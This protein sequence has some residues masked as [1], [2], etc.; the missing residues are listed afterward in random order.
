MTMDIKKPNDMFVAVLQK[1]EL[2]VFDLGKSEIV[3]DNTQLLSADDY[4]ALPKVQEMF[5]SESGNFDENAFNLAYSKA[6]NLY[7]ELSLDSALADALEYDPMDFT[8]PMDNKSID[9]R[10][11]IN[12]DYNPFK[13]KYSQT[14]VNSID[15]SD[16]SLRELAQ[17]SKIFDVKTQTWLD[18]SANDFGL[19]GSLF[20]D[21][22]VY[23]QWDS[24][25]QSFDPAVGKVVSHKKGDWKIDNNGNLYIETLGGRE[26]YGKQVVNPLDLLTKEGTSINKIDFF[27]SDGKDKSIF[28]TTMKLASEIAPY[29]IPG[30]NIYYGGVKMAIGL[31][32]ILP[33]FYK[34]AE[35]IL[36]G[37][38]TTGI[39]TDMW[40]GMNS[41]EGFMSKYSTKSMSDES[42]GSMWN[43]EQLGSLVTDVFSQIYEQRAAA[44]LSKLFYK[45]NETEH[46]NRLKGITDEVLENAVYAGKI[47]SKQEA[48]DIATRAFQK[49]Y[50]NSASA[51]KRSALAKNLSL[52]YMALSQSASV[53]EE[54]LAAGYDR[55][56][57][58][59]TALIAATGQYA[60]M[61]NNRMGDWFLDKTTGY[62]EN[63]S[64]AVIKKLAKN[65]L[66]DSKESF[67]AFDIDKQVGKAKLAGV[68]KNFKTKLNDTLVDPVLESEF[69]E[70]IV[71]RSVIEGIEEVTEQAAIDAA[72]GIADVMSSLGFTAKKGSFGGFNNV[73]SERGL[74][75]YL[76]NLIGGMLG[77]PMFE[78]ERSIISPALLGK[79]P[80]F[81]T[82]ADIYNIVSTGRTQEL[83]KEI[84]NKKSRFGNTKL[85]PVLSKISDTESVYLPTEALSQADMI[86]NN[87]IEYVKHVDKLINSESLGNSDEDLIKK[88]IIDQI[89]IKDITKSGVDKF[90][91]SDAKEIGLEIIELRDQIASLK[92]EESSTQ[93]SELNSKLTL[94]RQQYTDLLTSKKS[95]YYHGLSLFVLNP[96]L[97]NAFINMTVDSFVKEKY[98]K[99]YYELSEVEQKGYKAEF[100]KLKDLSEGDFKSKMKLMYDA[101]LEI[102]KSFSKSLK[103]YDKDGYASIKSGF[104]NILHNIGDSSEGKINY[105]DALKRLNEVNY[106][107]VKN[108]F[109]KHS[110][111]TDTNVSVGKFL[112]DNGYILEG[113]DPEKRAKLAN[114]YQEK[115]LKYIGFE[116]PID[117]DIQTVLNQKEQLN[118]VIKKVKSQVPNYEELTIEEYLPLIFG[119]SVDL[120][121]ETIQL[122]LTTEE[123]AILQNDVKPQIDI[124]NYDVLLEQIVNKVG[125]SGEIT[126]EDLNAAGL[127]E[128]NT[129]NLEVDYN[130]N[131][132]ALKNALNASRANYESIAYKKVGNKYDEE[133]DNL[134][135]EWDSQ[136]NVWSDLS[137][138]NKEGIINYL[139]N[140]GLP[141]SG[142]NTE[143]LQTILNQ[144]NAEFAKQIDAEIIKVSSLEDSEEKDLQLAQYE[145]MKTNLKNFKV[146]QTSNLE[147]SARRALLISYGEELM[148]QS[149]AF[150]EEHI[151]ELKKESKFIDDFLQDNWQAEQEKPEEYEK[152]EKQYNQ[153]QTILKYAESN[154]KINE[155]FKKLK[156]FEIEIFGWAGPISFFDILQ[157]NIDFFGTKVEVKSDFVRSDVQ[158]EQIKKARYIINAVKSVT[159]AMS[160]TKWGVD[161]LYG[162]NVMLNK[163]LEKEGLA[164]AYEL[165]DSQATSTIF[166][167][168]NLIESKLIY[169]EDLAKHNAISIIDNDNRIK[170]AFITQVTKQYLNK[171]FETSLINLKI[172]GKSLFSADDLLKINDISDP[173][174]KLIT[175][176]DIFYT[177]FHEINLSLEEKLS[178]LFEKFIDKNNPS[179]SIEDLKTSKDSV[180]TSDFAGFE[181]LDWYN[182]LH[183][184]ISINSKKFYSEYKNNIEK[185]LS[186]Q[187]DKKAPLFSQLVALRQVLG[188]V[189]N[190]AIISHITSSLQEKIESSD[191][192]ELPT[193]EQT[194]ALKNKL[195]LESTVFPINNIIAVRGSG[196]TGKSSVIANSLLRILLSNNLLG[197][198]VELQSIAPTQSTLQTLSREIKGSLD[199]KLD[200]FIASDFWTKYLTVEGLNKLSEIYKILQSNDLEKDLN[201]VNDL[202][203]N[204]YFIAGKGT[205]AILVRD[206]FFKD[207]IKELP[208]TETIVTVGDEMSKFNTLEWQILDYLGGQKNMYII[209]MGDELQNGIS[210]GQNPFSMENVIIPST[211][212]MKNPIRARNN[213]QNINNITLENFTRD[214]KWYRLHNKGNAPNRPELSYN[215]ASGNFLTGAKLT[216]SITESDLRKLNPDKQIVVITKDGILSDD[217]S[218]KLKKVF[219]SK[220][221]EV[222]PAEVQ[223]QEF[224]QVIIDLDIRVPHDYVSEVKNFYTLLTRAK[225]ATLGAIQTDVSFNNTFKLNAR[226]NTISKELIERALEER[227]KY[228]SSL[229]LTYTESK[230]EDLPKDQ[231][232]DSDETIDN[233]E[234]APSFGT[235]DEEFIKDP[236]KMLSYSFYNNLGI[237]YDEL[238]KISKVSQY[239]DYVISSETNLDKNT[240][241][242]EDL[243][244][245]LK[246]D[247][248]G[249]DLFAIPTI[250]YEGYTVRAII[251]EYVK[252]KNTLL[253][254]KTF[255]NNLFGNNVKIDKQWVLKKIYNQGDDKKLLSYGKLVNHNLNDNSIYA[256]GTYVTIGTT[257]F[258]VT[259]A[260]TPDLGNKNTFKNLDSTLL[261]S[262]YDI[263]DSSPNAEALI[264]NKELKVYGR[265]FLPKHSGVDNK[266]RKNKINS[267]AIKDIKN[268]FPG[269]SILDDKIRVFWGDLDFIKSELATYAGVIIDDEEVL[270]KYRFRPY[271]ILTYVDDNIEHSRLILLNS[272]P[273]S[274]EKF[275][276]EFTETIET[277]SNAD[278]KISTHH[279]ISKYRAWEILFNYIKFLKADDDTLV[280]GFRNDLIQQFMGVHR[281]NALTWEPFAE[282][283]NSLIKHDFDPNNPKDFEKWFKSKEINR[284]IV[285][286]QSSLTKINEYHWGNILHYVY[287]IISKD[288]FKFKEFLETY[289]KE[290]YYNTTITSLGS[291]G[292][293][294]GY[295][296]LPEEEESYYNMNVAIEP[297]RLLIDMNNLLLKNQKQDSVQ[298]N[299]I[300]TNITNLPTQTT[301]T[302]LI[303]TITVTNGVDRFKTTLSIN[304]NDV[305]SHSISQNGSVED[306]NNLVKAMDLALSNFFNLVDPEL[307]EGVYYND[308]GDAIDILESINTIVYNP[309]AYKLDKGKWIPITAYNNLLGMPSNTVFKCTI[310]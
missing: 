205:G 186:L 225:E 82:K 303:K 101:F 301:A 4:K 257:R 275:W 38:N 247:L 276:E 222:L 36:L 48:K 253:F 13:N 264:N 150:S 282:V 297:N 116:G 218:T 8:A 80:S 69:A 12:N 103:D 85:S 68:F 99:N 78:I 213:L 252:F 93:L 210:I 88:S 134:L 83:L 271:V 162:M 261:K 9:V 170:D 164:P 239:L 43:Y 61:S 30:F 262:I 141:S 256:I 130:T 34:A 200:E 244:E 195:N 135:S 293:G 151:A 188:Y 3:P 155:L 104:F 64:K 111:E 91:L 255:E 158:I 157:D 51:Q 39:E 185:E 310:S 214:V 166:K 180:L 181:L 273:R 100:E 97:H 215:D 286:N 47:T 6:A 194:Q 307:D 10:P 18:K 290:I 171:D 294:A 1:P 216:S 90:I 35:G 260:V 65:L 229:D 129:G 212:K 147:I 277:K 274:A 243:K 174:F 108:G 159:N 237:Y 152:L 160:S 94:K 306:A 167:D 230:K 211:I 27:D 44:S 304:L 309:K 71:K 133:F 305:I 182:W 203:D 59:F 196:G 258:F 75:N 221:I 106:E 144:Y 136:I 138:E 206:A 178:Q 240:I 24:D 29:L 5:R 26:V 175:I 168:L 236:N 298:N 220:T 235:T 70:N 153:I 201:K 37:D 291:E 2:D 177:R 58:G 124:Y 270:K 115:L 300:Q 137:E 77:G 114:E 73:F 45:I 11:I 19:F 128:S 192:S 266:G 245:I 89:Y 84:E 31:A 176:E 40:K 227:V 113:I 226:S 228:L 81:S 92:E 112:V 268:I 149:A 139:D 20:N 110:L 308:N 56:T 289:P 117:T 199:I 272:N 7:Q 74:Q 234:D 265:P 102:N 263:V 72:K 25:G 17:Q 23:A 219:G 238:S 248:T 54:A 299:D 207:F 179:Q 269:V 28:G 120:G 105:I 296:Y 267:V 131:L 49:G 209:L 187:G 53:Y 254:T 172:N 63:E 46:L 95:E 119:E 193:E 250:Q 198:G 118:T 161:N 232:K 217:L 126:S 287:P 109:L 281:N 125:L 249:T 121:D 21:T 292:K 197:N 280:E 33:T 16:L 98:N 148:K 145:A 173:E 146:M 87:A 246:S 79:A 62:T 50:E 191:I 279:L 189:E 165:L 96:N 223:G 107:L 285:T 283:F 52:G 278:A 60:L 42:Q 288:A 202:I 183:T 41:L 284:L 251:N 163:A 259:L 190:K 302:P 66:E 184:L 140:V 122:N 15:S 242:W 57:A 295:G 76:A 127:Q 55:R 132:E 14:G 142:F 169:F 204:K 233:D 67:K 241:T 156:E 208:A 123:L 86:A 224:E 32:S 22:L 143:T 154:Y 231:D